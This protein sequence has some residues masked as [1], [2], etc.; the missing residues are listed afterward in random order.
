MDHS[1]TALSNMEMRPGR[2]VAGKTKK[3]SG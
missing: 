1:Y 3:A 2:R